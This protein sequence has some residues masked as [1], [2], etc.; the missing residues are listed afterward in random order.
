MKISD[1]KMLYYYL[2]L[3]HSANP[4][5]RPVVISVFTHVIRPSVSTSV[6]TFKN[7]AKQNKFQLKTM[8]TTGDIVDLAKWIIDDTLSY[9]FFQDRAAET[10]NFDQRT[11][12]QSGFEENLLQFQVYFTNLNVQEIQE[13]K[14]L[15]V[16][17]IDN[18][19]LKLG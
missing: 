1:I 11:S 15:S 4:Q 16:S 12:D 3:I 6:P 19:Y 7:L 8:F 13:S 9:L 5:S 2:R 10:Y 14:V 17:K 18:L